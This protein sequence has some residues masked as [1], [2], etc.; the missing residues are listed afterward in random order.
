MYLLFCFIIATELNLISE[1]TI[2]NNIDMLIVFALREGEQE[3]RGKGMK[4][5]RY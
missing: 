1:R 5:G 4:Q 3:E 2:M